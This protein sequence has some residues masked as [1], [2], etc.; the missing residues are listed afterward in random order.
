MEATRNLKKLSQWSHNLPSMQQ[1][2]IPD[3]PLH[4]SY[5]IAHIFFKKHTVLTSMLL[6]KT[7]GCK[8]TTACHCQHTVA[9]TR[10]H[11]CQANSTHHKSSIQPN[12]RTLFTHVPHGLNRHTSHILL[13]DMVTITLQFISHHPR[14]DIRPTGQPVAQ[15]TLVRNKS[16]FNVCTR[17][18]TDATTF[19][20][21][22][23]YSKS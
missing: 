3:T 16:V 9:S 15:T 23:H 20:G 12:M 2:H 4:V 22:G 14:Q 7:H 10:P 8:A 19:P 11:V 1:V 21:D 18:H 6:F 17:D 5:L 13:T